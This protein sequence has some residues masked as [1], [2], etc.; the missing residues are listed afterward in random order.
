MKKILLVLTITM[1]SFAAFSQSE[2]SKAIA[3]Q[4]KID[5]LITKYNINSFAVYYGAT[6]FLASLSNYHINNGFITLS[7]LDKNVFIYDINKLVSIRLIIGKT[8]EL[9][10]YF[11]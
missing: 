5:S 10:F 9:F 4:N 6:L 8:N 11:D 1:F 7:F 3:F 2:N